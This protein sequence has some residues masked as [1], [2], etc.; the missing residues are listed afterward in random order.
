MRDSKTAIN[1][2]NLKIG[3][4]IH[5]CCPKCYIKVL[6]MAP[7]PVPNT[8]IKMWG[9]IFS[10]LP[11]CLFLLISFLEFTSLYPKPH[12]RFLPDIEI[13][14]W[15]MTQSTETSESTSS[16]PAASFPRDLLHQEILKQVLRGD[17]SIENFPHSAFD[18]T[19]IMNVKTYSFPEELFFL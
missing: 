19:Q 1:Q 8:Q 6:Q 18:N 16:T 11:F 10:F 15:S 13:N 4:Y 7:G 3:T 5:N 9:M 14:A 2:T 12:W 17:L